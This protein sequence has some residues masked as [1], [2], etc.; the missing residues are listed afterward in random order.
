MLLQVR[1]QP[2]NQHTSRELNLT[3][4]DLFRETVIG[5]YINTNSVIEKKR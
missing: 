1:L 5:K 3:Q 4:K 2:V